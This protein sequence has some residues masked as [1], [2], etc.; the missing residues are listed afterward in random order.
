[1]HFLCLRHPIPAQM[2]WM[3]VQEGWISLNH[4]APYIS[5]FLPSLFNWLILEVWQGVW[6]LCLAL[7]SII[8]MRLSIVCPR[9]GRRGRGEDFD[10][11]F[12]KKITRISPEYS[13]Y[14]NNRTAPSARW[15]REIQPSSTYIHILWAGIGCLR[16]RNCILLTDR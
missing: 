1:M 12:L 3:C 14:P 9:R 8:V 15:L 16:H 4:L 11:H 7:W 6:Q 13:D 10:R 5:A 2:M